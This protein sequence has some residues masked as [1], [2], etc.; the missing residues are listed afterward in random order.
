MTCL[1]TSIE[2]KWHSEVDGKDDDTGQRADQHQM[3]L[4][5]GVSMKYYV[6]LVPLGHR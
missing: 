2:E 4:K 5:F 6:Q 1:T 3:F